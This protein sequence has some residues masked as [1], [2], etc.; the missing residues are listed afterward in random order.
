MLDSAAGTG[1]SYEC[2]EV[3]VALARVMPDDAGLQQRYRELASRLPD[4]DRS[5]AERALVR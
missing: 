3:L 2:R 5:E 4:Y 1:S